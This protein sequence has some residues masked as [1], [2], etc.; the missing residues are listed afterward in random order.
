[1]TLPCRKSLR[2]SGNRSRLRTDPSWDFPHRHD[3]NRRKNNG[4]SNPGQSH[5]DASQHRHGLAGGA[6]RGGPAVNS[7]TVFQPS[8]AHHHRLPPAGVPPLR[9]MGLCRPPTPTDA[10]RGRSVPTVQPS[11]E[12]PTARITLTGSNSGPCNDHC[13]PGA[14]VPP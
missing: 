14:G 13:A 3:Y 12:L 8:K 2:P 9:F 5:H 7:L 1:M 6:Q 4:H 10:R 11:F